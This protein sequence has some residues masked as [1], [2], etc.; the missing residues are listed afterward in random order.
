MIILLSF[1]LMPI[2]FA[3]ERRHAH[4]VSVPRHALMSAAQRHC[5]FAIATAD[6]FADA[7]FPGARLR[8]AHGAFRRMPA[9]VYHAPRH[10]IALRYA[11]SLLTDFR[12][13]LFVCATFSMPR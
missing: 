10:V 4:G 9:S 5:A 11:M 13:C 6:A 2:P 3:T 8:F 1:E 12:L 7:L